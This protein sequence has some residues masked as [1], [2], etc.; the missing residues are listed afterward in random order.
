MAATTKSF[1][2]DI[3][4]KVTVLDGGRDGW[5]AG[6]M[7]RRDGARLYSIDTTDASGR[8]KHLWAEADEI[9]AAAE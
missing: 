3:N 9:E 8:P 6:L 7:V 4:D 2:F 5:V 1:A